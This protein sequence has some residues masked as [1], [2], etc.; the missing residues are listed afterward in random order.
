[1]YRPGP[2]RLAPGCC[3]GGMVI[4]VY[5]EAD[6]MVL[7]RRLGP[8]EPVEGAATA[9]VAI[10]DE[11]LRPGEVMVLV[12]YDGDSGARVSTPWGGL[13]PQQLIERLEAE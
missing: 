3:P 13:T 6:R 11:A 7:E 12:M 1:M 8:T 4:Q 2:D 10:A 5:G 9:D